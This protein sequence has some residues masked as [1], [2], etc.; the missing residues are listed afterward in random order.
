[1]LA[2]RQTKL[3]GVYDVTFEPFVDGRGFQIK[4]FEE[5]GFREKGFDVAWKQVIYNHSDKRNTLRGLYVQQAPY[6][7]GKLVACVRGEMFWV[8]VDVRKGSQSFGTWDGVVLTPEEGR[9]LFIL[10][11]FAHG[12]LSL[13]DDVGLL[14]LADN[15]HSEAHGVGIAWNDSELGIDWPLCGAEPIVSPAQSDN[16]SFKAFRQTVG[17]I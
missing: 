5:T 6:T 2:L 12:C 8:V 15:D 3:Q 13:A 4:P 11:G 9:A 14:L 16:A 17:G 10:P 1:M 7:E